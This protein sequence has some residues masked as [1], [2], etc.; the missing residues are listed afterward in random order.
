MDTIK[1]DH[2]NTLMVAHRGLSGLEPEN[3]IAAFVAAANRDYF[4]IET[5]VHVT[6]DGH[7]VVIHDDDTSRVAV[8]AL[9]V[10]GSTLAQLQALLLKDRDGTTRSDLRIPTLAEYLRICEKYE[11]TAVLELKNAFVRADIERM[12]TIISECIA[13]ERIIF[14][15]FDFNNMVILRELLP[16]ARL[17][18]LTSA[19][20]EE[21]LIRDLKAHRLDLDIYFPRLTEENIALLHANGIRVNCWTVDKPEKAQ[22]LAGW[23]VDFITSNILQ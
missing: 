9:P 16:E 1:I 17:Q 10:E 21:P 14:I 11:K 13:P 20:I 6:A 4:G 22:Q 8:D 2:A 23:G 3:T 12:L 15:S 7:F 18:F 5:D 19:P